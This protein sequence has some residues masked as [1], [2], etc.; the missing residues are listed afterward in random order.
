MASSSTDISNIKVFAE[1]NGASP[2]PSIY[3]SVSDTD[4]VAD[5]LAASFPVIDFSLLASEDP[6]IHT[7]AVDELAQAC[8]DWG[9]FM[10]TFPFYFF[11]KT[12]YESQCL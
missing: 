8:A 1:S 10:V 3:H 6:Q 12:I 2:I 5:D 9:F 11:F 4:D 7:K